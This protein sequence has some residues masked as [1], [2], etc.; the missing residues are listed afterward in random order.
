MHWECNSCEAAMG[1]NTSQGT[2]ISRAWSRRWSPSLSSAENL[3]NL[4][5][6]LL[7][8]GRFLPHT[9]VHRQL[10]H[11]QRL[12]TVAS[13]PLQCRAEKWLAVAV[14]KLPASRASE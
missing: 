3:M 7:L 11:P 9:K 14:G 13:P 2:L 1:V 4:F 10:S 5:R 12:V 6:R 8:N